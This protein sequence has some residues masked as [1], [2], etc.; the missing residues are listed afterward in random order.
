[1]DARQTDTRSL[2]ALI[3][4]DDKQPIIDKMRTR[5]ASKS[6]QRDIAMMKVR[7]A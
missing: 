7:P 3:I 2:A 1:M 6:T 4:A 5:L